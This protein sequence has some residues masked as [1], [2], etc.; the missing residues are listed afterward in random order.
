V[1]STKIMTVLLVS[2]SEIDSI[3]PTGDSMYMGTF[4]TELSILI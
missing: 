3:S 4:C 2:V 1:K